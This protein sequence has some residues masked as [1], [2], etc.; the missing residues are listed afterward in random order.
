MI[1]KGREGMRED[2]FFNF[3]SLMGEGKFFW[4]ISL[5]ACGKGR[6][7]FE[8]PFPHE[9]KS[10]KNEF[11]P[12]KMSKIS[13]F[14][15]E[16]KRFFFH[17]PLREKFFFNFPS[18]MG[19]G[20]FFWGI[21]LPACE[22]GRDCLLISLLNGHPVIQWIKIFLKERSFWIIFEEKT[23]SIN[24]INAEIS[25]KFFVSFI[26]YLFFNVNLLNICEQQKRKTTSIEFVNDVNVLTYS[27][28]TEKNCFILKKL[29]EIFTTWFRRHKTTFFSTKYELIHP[30][31]NFKNFNFQAMINLK[32]N[33]VNT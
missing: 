29:H 26:L 32:K 27:T 2:F 14:L 20:K 15:W 11:L 24:M 3:P 16:G 30:N 21:S 31:I 28:S 25:Q 13:D 6:D 7:F 23:N 1:A 12:T 22:K 4:G 5:P 10:E 18:P 9:K 33:T 8:F 19:E 17:F